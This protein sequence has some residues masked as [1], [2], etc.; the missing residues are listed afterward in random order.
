[1]LANLTA[2]LTQL[3]YYK[4]AEAY[5]ELS[6]KLWPNRILVVVNLATVKGLLGKLD[7]AEAGFRRAMVLEPTNVKHPYML[8]LVLLQ[9]G[10]REEAEAVLDGARPLLPPEGDWRK[11][12]RMIRGIM[13]RE[14]PLPEFPVTELV[15]ADSAEK[16]ARSTSP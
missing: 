7:E 3:K 5:S 4:T 12:H 10:R 14:I 9:K 2:T 11:A 8:A 1:M 13:L 16:K 15:G 6:V